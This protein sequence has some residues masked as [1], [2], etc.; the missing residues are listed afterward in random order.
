[1]FI[2]GLKDS[3]ACIQ[4]NAIQT[5]TKSNTIRKRLAK[6]F[7]FNAALAVLGMYGPWYTLPATLVLH[8]V[9]LIVT[10]IWI[11]D[12]CKKA[13]VIQPVKLY[14]VS[15]HNYYNVQVV[16]IPFAILGHTVYK[17]MLLTCIQLTATFVDLLTFVPYWP[18]TFVSLM[19]LSL[20]YGFVA[21]D[22]TLATAGYDVLARFAVIESNIVYFIGFGLPIT[23]A[24][25]FWN[26]FFTNAAI[27]NL[28]SVWLCLSPIFV[29]ERIPKL[30][31]RI[32]IPILKP[33]RRLLQRIV[34]VLSNK[35][36]HCLSRKRKQQ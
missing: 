2:Q 23:L 26:S 8:I 19:L 34:P 15:P 16:Q 32:Y 22:G 27:Y 36:A 5:Y 9:C 29:S 35:I 31:N 17:I 20:T 10:T 4:T 24:S 12:V 21:W 3:F 7:L 28:I 18:R 25:S 14:N 6:T 30:E 33:Y 1:M 11:N 13:L